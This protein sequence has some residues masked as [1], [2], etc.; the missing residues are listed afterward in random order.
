M[1]K[2]WKNDLPE[3]SVNQ[4]VS[5]A[6]AEQTTHLIIKKYRGKTHGQFTSGLQV[7]I[8]ISWHPNS[9]GSAI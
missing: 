1:K 4:G 8:Q 3:P 9:W 2:F 6:R 5:A 7:G